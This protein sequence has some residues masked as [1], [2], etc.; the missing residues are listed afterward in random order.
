MRA[1]SSSD[2]GRCAEEGRRHVTGPDP[3]A[4]GRWNKAHENILAVK[5]SVANGEFVEGLPACQVVGHA[6]RHAR[7]AGGR[8][9]K[10]DLIRRE[11][12]LGRHG[13]GVASLSAWKAVYRKGL[14]PSQAL[15]DF[16][17]MADGE[18]ARL[19]VLNNPRHPLALM[20][21]PAQQGNR[22]G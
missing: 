9:E 11:T 13:V 22:P 17:V 14:S 5:F 1:H 18:S 8:V 21:F 12:T 16:D 4:E 2:H 19:P 15:G 7:R 6:L 20:L 3:E 10:R